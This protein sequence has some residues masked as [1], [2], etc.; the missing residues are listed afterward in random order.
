MGGGEALRAGKIHGHGFLEEHMESR[1]KRVEPDRNVGIVR[2][3]NQ[4]GIARPAA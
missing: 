4:N 1:A 2:G 3:C